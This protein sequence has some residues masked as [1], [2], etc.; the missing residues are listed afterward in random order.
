MA[1]EEDAEDFEGV[2][3]IHSV[4]KATNSDTSPARAT[5]YRIVANWEKESKVESV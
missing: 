5:R 2:Y 4:L 3:M 1:E